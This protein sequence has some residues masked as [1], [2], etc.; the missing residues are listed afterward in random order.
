[1]SKKPVPQWLR[2]RYPSGP[3]RENELAWI[4]CICGAAITQGWVSGSH[5]THFKTTEAKCRKCGKE[6]KIEYAP[7][8]DPPP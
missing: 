4:Y 2:E 6:W 3:N 8:K 1:M 5:F 7:G